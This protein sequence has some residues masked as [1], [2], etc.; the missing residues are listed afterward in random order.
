MAL[1]TFL[2]IEV[3]NQSTSSNSFSI[4]TRKLPFISLTYEPPNIPTAAY[5]PPLPT[6][7][8]FSLL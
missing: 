7:R 3:P 6:S 2:L 8:L 4:S 1:R 5:F